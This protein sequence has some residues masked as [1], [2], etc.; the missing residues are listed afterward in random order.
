MAGDFQTSVDAEQNEP[1]GAHGGIR[2]LGGQSGDSRSLRQGLRL[3]LKY[4]IPCANMEL[5][6]V[7]TEG[8]R[9]AKISL[10]A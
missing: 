5:V 10:D 9:Y 3:P 8:C 7:V 2:S 4:D 1:T 6:I